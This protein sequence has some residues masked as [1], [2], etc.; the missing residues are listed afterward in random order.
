MSKSER[1]KGADGEREVC[2]ILADNLGISVNRNLSQTREGGCDIVCG[3]FNLEVKRRKSIAVY[4]WMDQ[5]AA[6]CEGSKQ[7]PVVICRGDGK[8]WLAIMPLEDW[9]DLAR[10][11]M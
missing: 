4:E 10:E 2:H 3:P 1:R 8:K 5:A 6:S 9:M 7:K 11:V